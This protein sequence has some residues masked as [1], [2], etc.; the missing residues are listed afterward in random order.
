MGILGAGNRVRV[1][2]RQHSRIKLRA[3]LTYMTGNLRGLQ[4]LFGRLL[5]LI[6]SASRLGPGL[7][8]RTVFEE[9]DTYRA[10][11]C[12]YRCTEQF[13]P[14][15]RARDN[16][17]DIFSRFSPR[18]SPAALPETGRS[19]SSVDFFLVDRHRMLWRRRV[20]RHQ[21]LLVSEGFDGVETSGLSRRV[22]S[23]EDPDRR[24]KREAAEYSR[25]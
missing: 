19:W 8:R 6:Q 15:R 1:A 18:G 20:D 25:N 7:A 9:I 13:L 3:T 17:V 4:S 14:V 16:F 23:E 22:V 2:S 24:R 21:P 5:D 11:R 10:A 12:W